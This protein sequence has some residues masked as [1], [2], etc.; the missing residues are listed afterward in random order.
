[1]TQNVPG[2]ARL[3]FSFYYK[4]NGALE[5]RLGR[6]NIHASCKNKILMP[7]VGVAEISGKTQSFWRRT[8]HQRVANDLMKIGTN[9]LTEF[10]NIWLNMLK[11]T[12]IGHREKSFDTLG[13]HSLNT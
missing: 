11:L 10:K 1:M 3:D 5:L 12:E 13:N 8:I 2:Q 4:T 6:N 7:T 9:E